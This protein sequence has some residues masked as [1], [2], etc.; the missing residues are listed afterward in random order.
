MNKPIKVLNKK[1][2]PLT[3]CHKNI[4]NNCQV[5][6]FCSAKQRHIADSLAEMLILTIISHNLLFVCKDNKIQYHPK[7]IMT[8]LYSW[9]FLKRTSSKLL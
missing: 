8:Y 5:T 1:S 2:N 9:R 6:K 3:S 7:I 4:G